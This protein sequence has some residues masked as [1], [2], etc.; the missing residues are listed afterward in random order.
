MSKLS[1][2]IPTLNEV[3]YL[4]GL[5]DALNEQTCR[6]DEIIVADAG[7]HDGTVEQATER[8]AQVVRGG[9]PSVGRNAGAR[10]AKGDL[11]QFFDAD[12]LPHPDYIARAAEEFTQAGYVVATCG[13][14]ALGGNPGD[15][16]LTDVTNLFLQ[17]V[18]PI[19]PHA[20]GYCILARREVHEAIG[21]YDETLKMSE[22]HDYVRRASQYGEFG[23]LT[24]VRIPVSM[25]RLEKEGLPA[26]ALKYLWCEL[27]GLEGKPIRSTPFEYEFGAF[28]QTTPASEGTLIDIAQLR[29]ELGRFENPLERLSQTGKTRLQQ[30][31]ELSPADAAREHLRLR[32]ARPDLDTLEQYLQQRLE[33]L[34]EQQ[35]SL[36]QGWTRVQILPRESIRLVEP[37]GLQR[38]RENSSEPDESDALDR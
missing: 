20:P 21:G 13:S 17:I 3:E 31:A 26:L 35:Q 18:R 11:F 5:L 4:P 8:G 7:S 30:L 36:K 2:I 25:R 10:V 28:Q 38:R 27:Q 23:F 29:A 14:E 19:A 1:V 9:M 15:E 6:P 22:D 33:L 37:D 12:V 34:R 32:L 24:S 16:F